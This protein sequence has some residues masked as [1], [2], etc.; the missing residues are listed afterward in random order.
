[1]TE[2]GV[3]LEAQRLLDGL[4]PDQRASVVT[5]TPAVRVIA[6]AG[7]GKTRV[8]TRR[9][10]WR[11]LTD[12]IDPR[13]VLAV[14]FTRRAASELST[15]LRLLGLR[16]NVTAGT[17]HGI[18]YAQ[19]RGSWADRGVRPPAL[20]TRKSGFVSRLLPRATSAEPGVVAAEIEWAKSRMV[21]PDDYASAA[22]RDH[23]SPPLP[24]RTMQGVYEQYEL[25]KRD[26]RLVDF[27]DLLRLCL[28]DLTRDPV[29]A[30]AQR[31]RFRHLFIDEY[32][33]LNP[34][35]FALLEAWRDNRDDICIVGDP[36]QAIY[37]WNGADVSFLD[38]FPS[39]HPEGETIVLG[40]SFRS[41]AQILD[42]A[43]R[44]LDPADRPGLTAHRPDGPAPTVTSHDNEQ[45]EAQAVAR[46]LRLA[47]AP[48]R[49]WRNLA[50][51]A[52]THAQL[53]P[54][55]ATLE[56]ASIPHRVRGGSP[57]EHR[58][59]REHLKTMARS[60]ESFAVLIADLEADLAD[61]TEAG[62]SASDTAV[63]AELVG[64]AV[65]YE[66]VDTRPSGAGFSEWIAASRDEVSATSNAVELATFHAAKGLEWPVVHLVGLEAGLVPIAHAA[67]DPEATSEERRLLYV[68]LTRAGLELHLHWARTRRFGRTERRRDPSPWLA[69]LAP[70]TPVTPAVGPD[71]RHHLEE[72]R[73]QLANHEVLDLRN[74]T[75]A[76]MSDP[77]VLDRLIEWRAT[78][79]WGARVS[80]TA[81]L[82]DH[83]L[84]D[85]AR[86]RPS[87]AAELEAIPGVGPV[88]A[89]RFGHQ[90]LDLVGP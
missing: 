12:Q 1:M 42:T 88:K 19:L 48:D 89:A 83:V 62:L 61:P 49:P 87:S 18:A 55:R 58:L 86:V 22:A 64:L 90:L 23:R 43:E 8:L 31:W 15:R 36:N 56:T 85:L 17:I 27:D 72:G 66:A 67:N 33:D 74:T 34:L 52:R 11:V 25:A 7:S 81:V 45:A 75:T 79:A 59:V 13:H 29:F 50:V 24:V 46:R 41:T 68:S 26:K 53:E 70:A 69:D 38:E 60:P 65:E 37:G 71:W 51:L 80:P 84:R 4:T 73:T 30:K 9:I 16:D 32:Q 10:A 76:Q 78:L 44:V 5:P 77:I 3:P 20:L 2:A 21:S 63:L 6:G 35:Q 57:G 39:R 47:H 82:P 54:I 14:T 28:R 40:D